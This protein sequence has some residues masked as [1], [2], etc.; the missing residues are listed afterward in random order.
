M[1]TKLGIKALMPYPSSSSS[2]LVG[3]RNV[4]PASLNA[5]TG[6]FFE[7][8]DVAESIALGLRQPGESLRKPIEEGWVRFLSPY[9]W[10]W[11]ATF[12]FKDEV[13][14]ETAVKRFK[15]WSRLLDESNGVALRKPAANRFRCMWVRGLEYQ[16]R[17][18]V[19]FHTVIG[20][21]PNELCTKVQC[22]LWQEVWFNMGNTGIARIFNVASQGDVISYVTKYCAK[23]GEIDISPNL[24][25]Q[26]CLTS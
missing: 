26:G 1:I 25:L 24:S 14:P 13:H 5:V 23:G 10:Q 15:F 18:I 9:Q 22:E 21:L 8:G 19:H 11:F 6:S 16:K 20:N 3:D 17:G 4:E 7:A 2:L 12:T